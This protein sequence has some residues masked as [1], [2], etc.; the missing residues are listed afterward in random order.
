MV[1]T[2]GY[3]R[4]ALVIPNQKFGNGALI[5][6]DFFAKNTQIPNSFHKLGIYTINHPKNN[7]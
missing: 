2:I 3:R 6:A 4:N 5:F 7:L 1:S